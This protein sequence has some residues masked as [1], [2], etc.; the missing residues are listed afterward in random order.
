MIGRLLLAPLRLWRGRL[1]WLY[2]V[3]A[4]LLP[5]ALMLLLVRTKPIAPAFAYSLR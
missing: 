2:A 5:L 1:W 3:A 4:F